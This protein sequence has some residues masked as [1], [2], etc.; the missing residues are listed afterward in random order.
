MDFYHTYKT[1]LPLFR[2]A[3]GVNN[4]DFTISW[5]RILPD[6]TGDKPNDKGVEFY[7][8]MMRVAHDNGMSTSCTL[9]HWDLPQKLQDRYKGWM[10]ADVVKDFE[11]YARVTMTALGGLCSHWLSMNEPRTFASRL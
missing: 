1:D 11:N 2:K 5:T 3:L 9:Y 7:K 4:Y 6:G 10:S 8:D